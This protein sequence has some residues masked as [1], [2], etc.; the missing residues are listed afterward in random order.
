MRQSGEVAPVVRAAGWTMSL[1]ARHRLARPADTVV[2]PDVAIHCAG[3]IG[4]VP[5]SET[6]ARVPE[7]VIELLGRETAQRDRAPRGAKFLSYEMSGVREYYY[8]WPDGHDA[9]G[10]HLRDGRYVPA[11]RDPEGFFSSPLLGAALRL[12]PAGLR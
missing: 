1:D 11:P 7:L 5:A 8:A 9:A 6:V 2:F 3:A 12:V 10:F 4:F